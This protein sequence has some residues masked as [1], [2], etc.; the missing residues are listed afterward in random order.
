[1]QE[2]LTLKQ[3][4]EHLQLSER[5]IY[6]LLER[7]ELPGFKVGGHWRF[8]RA[9]VDY[10]L[11]LRVGRMNPADL[12]KMEDEWEAPALSLSEAL[13]VENAL[14]LLPG[15]SSR[16]VIKAM[17]ESTTFPEP[18]DVDQILQRVW[19]REQLASTATE[20]GVAFL[21][22]A[23]WEPRMMR[24]GDLLAV[25][26]LA[27]PVDFSALG[28]GHT[29]LLFLLLARDARQHLLLLAK[30]TRL[31]RHPGFLSA[32]RAA[33]TAPAVVALVRSTERLLF[34]N[35]SPPP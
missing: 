34:Y 21:H 5:T 23:R 7:G 29:D 4:A 14:L 2:V 18:V 25:G 17:I 30:A 3:L 31:S 10:W 27:T 8:R 11:D 33:P 12:S 26:R 6:R 15:G 1:M 19:E 35:T 20:A 9:V 13:S 22:T 32:M 16:T 28:G 24:H